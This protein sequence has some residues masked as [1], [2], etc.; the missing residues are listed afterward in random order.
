[1][2]EAESQKYSPQLQYHSKATPC[3]PPR[4][5]RAENRETADTINKH[6]IGKW[7]QKGQ[8][9]TKKTEEGSKDP[10]VTT[11]LLHCRKRDGQS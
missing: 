7:P 9:R 6:E 5:R 3:L 11:F 1:V 4:G 8:E 2:N 10:F